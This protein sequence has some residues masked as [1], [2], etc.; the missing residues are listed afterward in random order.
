M[1]CLFHVSS[2]QC[3]T[4][5]SPPFHNETDPRHLEH[6]SDLE[7]S[8]YVYMYASATL[9]GHTEP[10]GCAGTFRNVSPRGYDMP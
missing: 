4:C 3:H 1:L 10:T 2:I 5:V 9:L 7:Q 6:V 8:I